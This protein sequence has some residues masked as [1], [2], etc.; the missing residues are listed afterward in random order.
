MGTIC[1]TLPAATMHHTSCTKLSHIV[2]KTLFAHLC[3][4]EQ[5][6]HCAGAPTPAAFEP[7]GV[8]DVHRLVDAGKVNASSLGDQ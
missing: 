7:Q 4:D 5:L 3:R 6:Y 2:T 8:P 1:V